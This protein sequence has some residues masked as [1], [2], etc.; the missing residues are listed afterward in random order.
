MII[1]A[2]VLL[3]CA[4]TPNKKN[5]TQELYGMIYDGNNKPVYNAAVYINGTYAASSDIH[6]HFSIPKVK[7]KLP[8]VISA[9]KPDYETIQTE[10]ADTDPAYI[11]YMRMFSVDQLIT[12]AEDALKEKNWNRAESFLVRAEKA[13]GENPSIKYL[14]GVLAFYKNQY[15]EAVAV[16]RGITEAEKNAAFVYLFI[17]DLYQYYLEEPI[18]AKAFLERFLSLQY[19][20][21]V[22]NRVNLLP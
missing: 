22:R 9:E 14:R 16:L 7:P 1:L 5:R 2:L 10:F 11:L 21:D 17:A 8:C 15:A 18:Q 12:E 3:S 19:D 20:A 4:T 6:G 13:G